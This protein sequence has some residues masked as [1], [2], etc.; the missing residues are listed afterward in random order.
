[1]E[2]VG[3][4]E[5]NLAKMTIHCRVPSLWGSGKGRT[6]VCWRK[7][8]LSM[9]LVVVGIELDWNLTGGDS[10]GGLCSRSGWGLVHTTVCSFVLING[11]LHTD[12]SRW[13][14]VSLDWGNHYLPS[15]QQFSLQWLSHRL[16]FLGWGVTLSRGHDCVPCTNT[17][18]SMVPQLIQS[19]IIYPW[20]DSVINSFSLPE[21]VMD[22]VPCSDSFVS[23]LLWTERNIVILLSVFYPFLVCFFGMM[24]SFIVIL[25]IGNFYFVVKC[26]PWVELV[27]DCFPW[28]DLVISC[29]SLS[30][31][32]HQ[33]FTPGLTWSLAFFP[34]LTRSSTISPWADWVIDTFK[35]DWLGPWL[36]TPGLTRLSTFFPELTQSLTIFPWTDAVIDYL[37]LDWLGYWLFSLDWL[38]HRLFSPG[39][40][41]SLTTHPWTD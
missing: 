41:R 35:L 23:C 28:I 40:T 32:G 3:W 4:N 18:L 20:A 34:G 12:L 11:I 26:R 17:I 19:L 21:S 24:L 8:E 37:L 7:C 13:Y 29:F 39:L 22:Y 33:L 5:R 36:L 10:L 9:G 16:Y 1:M 31:L 25:F 38:S 27:I 14:L 30:S 15:S 6:N 2:N